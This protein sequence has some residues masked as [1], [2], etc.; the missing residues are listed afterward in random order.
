[1]VRCWHLAASETHS[2]FFKFNFTSL[3]RWNGIAK[4][5]TLPLAV[6]AA[7]VSAVYFRVDQ[8]TTAFNKLEFGSYFK[9]LY[10]KAKRDFDLPPPPPHTSQ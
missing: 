6:V 3:I 4:F 7:A 5:S 1:M 8:L 9:H 2:Y 10:T